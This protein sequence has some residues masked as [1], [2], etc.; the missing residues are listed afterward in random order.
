MEI[1]K[2]EKF[3]T[4]EQA[5]TEGGDALIPYKFKYPNSDMIVEV[6][7]KP[8]TSKALQEINQIVKLDPETNYDLEL[9]KIAL[10]NVDDTLF[11]DEILFKL[12][13][14]VVYDLVLKISEFSG[15]DMDKIINN[16]SKDLAGF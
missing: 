9:L 4:L 7:L 1:N 5:I 2:E 10:F 11:D 12:P 15:V 6:K 16:T 13:A 3:I 14:G 8:V